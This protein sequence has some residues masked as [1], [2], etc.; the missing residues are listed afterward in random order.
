MLEGNEWTGRVGE[1]AQHEKR[2][3]LDAFFVLQDSGGLQG[4]HSGEGI[5]KICDI[6]NQHIYIS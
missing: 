6:R 5:A 4:K 2:V 3:Q 1:E